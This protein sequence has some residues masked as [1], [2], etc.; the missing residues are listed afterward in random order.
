MKET[1]NYIWN[2][3][4]DIYNLAGGVVLAILGYFL[5]I[6][7]IIN[8]MML[9]FVVDTIVGYL[10]SRKI[11]NQRFKARLIWEK[12]IPRM[13][14]STI[15]ISLLFLWDEVHN[16]KFIESYNIA[17]WFISGLLLVSILDNMY[18]ITGWTVLPFLSSFIKKRIDEKAELNNEI[19]EDESTYK[20]D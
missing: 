17:G 1:F 14:F 3:I 13:L 2:W 7:D 5:P 10:K 6:K 15:I 9:L 19:S 8:F 20:E 4:T 16:Q 12:T 18:K 11:N